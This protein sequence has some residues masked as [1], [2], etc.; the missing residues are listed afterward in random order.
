MAQG[1]RSAWRNAH[2]HPQ[3]HEN[4]GQSDKEHNTIVQ[5]KTN[6]IV[7]HTP[8]PSCCLAT[9][10]GKAKLEH[11]GTPACQGNTAAVKA[12]KVQ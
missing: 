7:L 1:T 4:K 3:T 9:A 8:D 2:L 10:Q 12:Q 6:T 11:G 5:A